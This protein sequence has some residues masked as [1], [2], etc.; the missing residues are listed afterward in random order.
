MGFRIGVFSED[1]IEPHIFW[2]EVFFRLNLLVLIIAAI[3]L[4]FHS[5]F[6]K[7]IGIYGIIVA[8]IKLLFVYVIGTPLLEWFTVFTAL[9]YV[10]LIV[11]NMYT[12]FE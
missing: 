4:F 12:T 1:F 5:D 11:Y 10:G 7:L 2:S 9:G 8:I 3:A 6:I